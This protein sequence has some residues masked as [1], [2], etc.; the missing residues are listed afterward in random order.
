MR[1]IRFLAAAALMFAPA[2]L[3][4]QNTVAAT[5]TVAQSIRWS[6]PTALDLGS[7]TY[8]G[9]ATIAPAQGGYIKVDFNTAIVVTAPATV[10]LTKG[11]EALSVALDCGY[12]ADNSRSGV[13][14]FD[15]TTGRD[16]GVAVG[17]SYI[18]IGGAVAAGDA[19]GLSAGVYSGTITVT[20]T[21]TGT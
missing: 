19:D 12:G 16:P 18:Y 14:G 2:A 15:C 20:A 11:S 4:A 1:T 13:I 17:H 7:I 9:G 8:G 6:E 10:S 21:P 5:A 3:S